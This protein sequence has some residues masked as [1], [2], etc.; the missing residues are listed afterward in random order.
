MEINF[1]TLGK[2]VDFKI[3]YRDGDTPVTIYGNSEDREQWHQF[4]K[5]LGS[6]AVGSVQIQGT[7]LENDEAFGQIIFGGVKFILIELK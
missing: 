6:G 7:P 1:G 4:F 2:I 5:N 3:K